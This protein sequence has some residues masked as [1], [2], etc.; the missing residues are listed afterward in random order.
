MLWLPSLGLDSHS[1]SDDKGEPNA[2]RAIRLGVCACMCVLYSNKLLRKQKYFN[3]RG[4]RGECWKEWERNLLSANFV[5]ME[6]GGKRMK[7]R[8]Q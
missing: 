5:V 6:N 4:G 1:S 7:R 8:K 3:Y 2:I